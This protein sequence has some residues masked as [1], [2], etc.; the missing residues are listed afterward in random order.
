MFAN[1]LAARRRLRP[2][3][4][5]RLPVLAAPGHAG[6]AHA[7]GRRAR[8][9]RSARRGCGQKGEAAL[10]A[11]PARRRSGAEVELLVERER[12]G[13]HAG[14]RRDRACASRRRR[15]S[16]SRP[17]SPRPTASGCGAS[18]SP[19]RVPRERQAG[20][21]RGGLFGHVPPLGGAPPPPAPAERCRRRSLHCS[22][23]EPQPA[24]APSPKR[25]A[26]PPK[27]QGWFQ[28][29]KAGLTKTSAKLSEDIAGIFTKRKLDADTLQELEDLLIQADLGV[30][31]AMRITA[32]LAKGR[33]DKE[34]APEEVRAVLAAEVERALAPGGQAAAARGRAPA[35]RHPGGRR[36]RH[37]QDHHHRQARPALVA[38]GQEGHAGGRRHVP[39]RRH[40]A[41]QDLGRAHRR[42]GGRARRRRR[43]GR[44]G[45][46]CAEARRAKMAATCC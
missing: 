39:R 34:I 44:A 40:R 41:A 10:A 22:S 33:Y 42:R 6:G 37:R 3:L 45:L 23:P 2:D 14:F 13:A 32:A 4:P 27:K 28:R 1:S 12:L 29:L 15:G 9:S 31:T 18:C 24:D 43:C 36:Q 25:R 20:K 38:R 19:P 26:E 5:A 7:A 17:A 30:E 46:R 8:S 35:A 16:W 11:L 21:I